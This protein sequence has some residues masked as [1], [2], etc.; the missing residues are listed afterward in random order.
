[1]IFIQ[2]SHSSPNFQLLSGVVVLHRATL[3]HP[4]ARP[5]DRERVLYLAEMRP[6]KLC[7]VRRRRRSPYLLLLLGLRTTA[8]SAGPPGRTTCSLSRSRSAAATASA[9]L[10]RSVGLSFSYL[11][12]LGNFEVVR[13]SR[14]SRPSET[15][16][17]ERRRRKSGGHRTPVR[18][19]GR[20]R[21]YLS[22]IRGRVR[23]KQNFS[24]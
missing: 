10:A 21:Y 16:T 1:M 4:A 12:R 11:V 13:P 20:R 14:R 6:R 22:N 8:Q 5:I 3:S 2:S 7:S 15:C 9:A 17:G 18:R 19:G 23:P 24:C